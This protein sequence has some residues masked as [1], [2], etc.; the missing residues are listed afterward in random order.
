MS[1]NIVN[2]EY[3][4]SNFVNLGED[5]LWNAIQLNGTDIGNL[6]GADDGATLVWNETL[7]QWNWLIKLGL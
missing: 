4:S 6:L 7:G 2:T 3:S 5:P 1:F